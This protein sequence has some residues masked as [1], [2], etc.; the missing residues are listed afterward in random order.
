MMSIPN[1]VTNWANFKF[2]SI[3]PS[4][5]GVYCD[6]RRAERSSGHLWV[7]ERLLSY[8]KACLM[9]MKKSNHKDMMG[10]IIM[11]EEPESC[12]APSR[13]FQFIIETGSWTRRH[14]CDSRLSGY[15]G[16]HAVHYHYLIAAC[17]LFSALLNKKHKK[18]LHIGRQQQTRIMS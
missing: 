15:T 18:I 10:K 9:K 3:L 6:H 2:I 1:T 14:S 8:A 4:F 7:G 11:I 16:I 5:R 17:P 13:L 12:I